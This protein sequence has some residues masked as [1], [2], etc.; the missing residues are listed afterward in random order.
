MP[1]PFDAAPAITHLCAADPVFAALIAAVGPCTL[2]PTGHGFAALAETV[3]AQQLS[4]PAA[5]TIL[6]RL[7]AL[8]DLTPTG[9]LAASDARLREV[10]LSAQKARALRIAA[11]HFLTGALDS[12][13]ELDDH[14]ALTMLT[15]LPGVGQWTAEIY[16]LFA[17][18][19]PDIL[20]AADLGLRN[21]ARQWY[22]LPVAPTS[23]ALRGLAEVWRPHRSVAAWYLWRS[24]GVYRPATERA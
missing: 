21:A 14:A 9:M 24:R 20:P 23:A 3:V 13:P 11:S 10:G 7:A 8:T 12:L 4:V 16:L 15:A 19:R 1:T 22:Q 6:G 5:A 2:Q 18:G 17:L